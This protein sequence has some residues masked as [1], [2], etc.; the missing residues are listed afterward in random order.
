MS[1]EISLLFFCNN[2][3]S[4]K[5]LIKDPE[6][7]LSKTNRTESLNLY[8]EHFMESAIK[9]NMNKLFARPRLLK[10]GR[11]SKVFEMPAISEMHTNPDI[12]RNWVF[13]GTLDAELTY[14]LFQSLK[15]LMKMLPVKFEK[16][17]NIWDVYQHFWRPF[18]EVL[19]GIEKEGIFINLQHLC[20]CLENASKDYFLMRRGFQDFISK[21]LPDS[22][23]FNPMSNTQM[24][25]V[26]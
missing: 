14:F 19:T 8:K 16:L 4:Y 7:L 17:N 18:G 21:H 10:N 20:A 22:P 24:Q 15:K 11:E 26:H 5:H 25:Q 1:V 23:E 9:I 3:F 6:T 12:V 2:S 13:Y